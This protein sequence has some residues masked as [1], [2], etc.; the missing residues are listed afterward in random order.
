MKRLT[1]MGLLFLCL[2]TLGQEAIQID[3]HTAIGPVSE[4]YVL[5]ALSSAKTQRAACVVLQID[6]PGGLSQSM[7]EINKAILASSVPVIG[8]VAPSGARAASAGMYLLYATSLA[9]MAPGTNVGAATPINLLSKDDNSARMKK[10]VN[11][12]KAYIRSLAQLHGR[13]SEWAEKAVTG[14]QSLSA[15]E[16][17]QKGVINLIAPSVKVLLQKANGR[18][19]RVQNHQVTLHTLQLQVV[20]IQPGWKAQLLSAITNP[21]VAYILL[22]VGIYGLFFEMIH[23]GLIAPGVVGAICLILALFAL[24]TLPINYAGVALLLVGL[25]LMFA[26]LFIVSF[27]VL[28]I[29]GMVAFF[30]GS[31]LLIETHHSAFALPWW[32]A[33]IFTL[34]S[35]VLFLWAF[36]FVLKIR[37][38][39]VHG[40]AQSV[41]GRSGTIVMDN[42]K[43]WVKIAGELWEVDTDNRLQKGLRAGQTVQVTHVNGL[44]VNITTRK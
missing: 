27:G 31:L 41:V 16:A 18:V 2:T 35:A 5:S 21:S 19:V 10:A 6:T 4:A 15:K 38:Q 33:L 25:A 20:K 13:N 43:V 36:R 9:A 3:L 34:V 44:K 14:A 7:R 42:E 32:V 1:L 39:P 23:P 37:Y 24:H 28:A 40:G 30:F 29:G 12:A 11:D 26:E 8:Y 22:L 17:L